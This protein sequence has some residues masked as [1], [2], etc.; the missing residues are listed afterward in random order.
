MHTA[1]I[2]I[3]SN[4]GDRRHLIQRALQTLGQTPGVRIV[5]KSRLFKTKPEGILNQP[6]FL[7][8]AA[9]L[10]TVHTAENLLSILKEVEVKCGRKHR[11]CWG[12][13]EIDL[14][15]LFYDDCVIKTK[16]L[17]VPHP[18]LSERVFVLKPLVQIAPGK[19][20]PVT[21]KR[22]TTLLKEVDHGH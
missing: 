22:I 7:N 13:R 3:G 15:L 11:K 1:Y 12:P 2:G 18:H 20:H 9:K 8:G 19:I 17:E 21:R 10:L 16:K 5:A 4:L 6:E 14:D